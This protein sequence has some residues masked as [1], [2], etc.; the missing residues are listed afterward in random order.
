MIST[1]YIYSNY[2]LYVKA[3]LIGK[4]QKILS[5]TTEEETKTNVEEYVAIVIILSVFVNLDVINSVIFFIF[6]IIKNLKVQKP[7]VPDGA[8]S[9]TAS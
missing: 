8:K 2:I 5:I 1:I 7:G 6:R 9:V 3:Y 4:L